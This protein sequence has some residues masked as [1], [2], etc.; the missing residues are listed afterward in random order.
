MRVFGVL[1]LAGL[2]SLPALTFQ[3]TSQPRPSRS[4]QESA[5]GGWQENPHTDV[6]HNYVDALRAFPEWGTAN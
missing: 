6:V 3:P 4:L 2:L 5:T 1:L